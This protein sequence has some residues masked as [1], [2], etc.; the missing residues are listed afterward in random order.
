MRMTL[1]RWFVAAML[2]ANLG[3]AAWSW[4]ALR[5]IGL[6]PAT[7]RDPGRMARQIRPTALQLLTPQAAADA[8][9]GAVRPPLP[10]ASAVGGP[11]SAP[12]AAAATAGGPLA[13]LEIGPLDNNAAVEAAE[14]ALATVLPDRNWV[15]EVRP[16]PALYVVFVGPILSRESARQRRDELIKLK[17]SFEAVELP[18]GDQGGYS[19]GHHDSEAA[20]LAAL[21]SFRE[22]GLRN[23]SVAQLREAGS[24]RTWLLMSRLRPAV[25]D[26]VRE[27]PAAQFG[28]LA[29]APCTLGSVMSATPAR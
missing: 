13:C 19:L 2:L 8:K 10:A 29:A 5:I 26:A 11:A 16:A 3:F 18:G 27:L 1:L 23:A 12:G 28:G 9:A 6:A 7:E 14:R 24:P 20:A 21:D 4:G 17:M 25:A 22:R 15:R